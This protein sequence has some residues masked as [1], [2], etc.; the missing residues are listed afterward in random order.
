MKIVVLCKRAPQNR[1]LW[2]RPYGRFFHLSKFL[3][4]SGDDVHFVLLNYKKGGEFKEHRDGLNWYSVNLL[5]NPFHYYCVVKNLV[6]D[7]QADWIIGF[8]DTYFG[9]CANFVG[10]ATG[11][12]VLIDAYDNYESYLEWCFPLHKLWRKSLSECTALSAAG[13]GLLNLMASGRDAEQLAVIEMAADPLFSPG[14][15]TSS[16]EVM[17]LPEDTPIIAYSGSLYQ[18]RGVEELFEVME[19]LFATNPEIHWVVSGRLQPDVRLPPNCRH[20]GYVDDDKVVE[21]IRSADLMLCVS[22]PGSFGDYSYPVKVYEALAAGVPVVAFDTDS[23]KFVM[24]NNTQGLVPFGDIEGMA[25]RIRSML[26]SPSVIDAVDGG[27]G[28]QA[29]LLRQRLDSWSNQG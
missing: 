23:V 2:L 20:L 19:S 29:S 8:S 13:P 24:R 12:K 21:V 26:R 7:I 6:K 25:E 1:D 9:I 4:D 27:W 28:V 18:N 17:G 3:A 5:P 22:K 11:A 14:S 16:R 10:R 15:K